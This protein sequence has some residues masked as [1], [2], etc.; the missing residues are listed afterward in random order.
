MSFSWKWTAN[1]RILHVLPMHHIHGV[2]NVLLT[3]LWNGATVEFMK[4]FDAPGVRFP[5][6]SLNLS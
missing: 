6:Y 3:G 4:A 5:S 1:D 2:V